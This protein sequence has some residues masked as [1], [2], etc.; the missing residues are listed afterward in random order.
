MADDIAGAVV[1]ESTLKASAA[2]LHPL[3]GRGRWIISLLLLINIVNFIDRQL[4]FVLIDS[5]KKDLRLSDAE[6]GL[7]AGLSFA[8][9]YSFGSVLLGRVADRSSPRR[10]LAITLSFWSLLTALTGFAQN[11]LHLILARMGVAAGEAA[12]APTAHALIS[13]VYLPD[14]RALALAIFSM[15]VPIGST[16]GLVLGGWIN[17]LVDWRAAFFIVGLPGLA[18]AALAWFA[19]PDVERVRPTGRAPARLGETVAYLFRLRSFRHMAIA[20]S[21]YACGSYAMNVFAAAFLIRVHEFTTAQAGLGFGIAFGLGGGIG[22]FAGGMM[23]DALGKRDARWRQ[24]IPAIG[25]LLSVPTALAAWLVADAGL[26][27]AMLTLT[28][29]FGLLYFAPTFATAQSLVPDE[30]RATAAAILLF[31][32]T[33]VGSSAGPLIVG[34][35]SDMLVPRFGVMSLRY[36]MCL[37]AITMLWSAWHFY[38]ASRSLPRDLTRPE[39]G[40]A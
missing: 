25:Q 13:R 3:A 18:I 26:S 22:T 20:C 27:V 1:P 16:M 40:E 34:W 35:A 5:I 31:C 17:D 11:F 23:S 32:L 15:G 37:M 14:R 8:V 38:W 24:R 19:L 36:A 21:L 30:I 39:L 7:M 33:I 10:V 29:L 2:G 9:V 12:T 6:I 4:P 28:Y